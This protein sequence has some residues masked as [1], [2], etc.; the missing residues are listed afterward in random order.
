MTIPDDGVSSLFIAVDVGTTGARAA[1][2][3]LNGRVLHEARE[4]YETFAAREGWAEQDPRDWR[5]AAVSA[6]ARLA[7]QIGRPERILAIGLTGQTPTV[8]PFDGGMRPLGP[9]MLYR[10]NR[11]VVQAAAMRERVGD[12]EMHRRTGHVPDAF[13]IGPKVL[14]LREF[15]PELFARTEVF[16]QPRDLVLYELTGVVAT[17]LSHA[18]A[19]LLFDL[20]RSQWALDLFDTFEL[21]PNLF[22]QAILSSTIA[23]ELKPQMV[24]RTGIPQGTPV[25][26]GAGDSQCAAFG[27][28]VTEPGPISEMAGASSCLNSAV[29]RPLSDVRVTH[30][31]HVVP[32]RYTTETGVNTSGAAISWAV[33]RLGYQSYEAFAAD[34]DEFRRGIPATKT[35][36]EARSV[37]PLFRPYLADGERD[38]PD[39]RGA[40]LG[41]SNRHHRAALAYSIVEGVAFAV[42]SK[43]HVL[44]D[45]GAPVTELRV[46]GGGG[47]LGITG[48]IK[49]DVLGVPVLHLDVDAAGFGVAML[50]ASSIGAAAEAHSAIGKV[51]D[52][53]RRIEPTETKD[54]VDQRIEWFKRED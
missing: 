16:L 50:A 23:G 27:A 39:A 48:Q 12:L 21:D 40:L 11:A 29:P 8:A 17:D 41:I 24:S 47:R 45:S 20:T 13:H 49:A 34:V 4:S 33:S 42:S 5:D 25:V 18:N 14:W 26:I 15:Q 10:D 6:V 3:D 1:A 28:G 2:F 7:S 37:A 35:V 9:G 46:A 51:L 36:H 22:P 31:R 30:Y 52:R 19:T 38:D 54:F 43:I 53:A 32:D 44:H